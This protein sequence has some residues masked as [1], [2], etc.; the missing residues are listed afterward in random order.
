MIGSVKETQLLRSIQGIATRYITGG[1]KGTTFN[2]L[3]AH[4][5]LPPIDLAFRITQFCAASRISMLPPSHPLY[6]LACR[7]A[8][9]LIRSH[10]SPLHCLFFITGI[11]LQ[12]IEKILPVQC[13]PNYHPMMRSTIASNKKEALQSASI[14]HQFTHYKVYCDR[15]GFKGGIG[16]A[17]VLYKGR[18]PVKSL[19]YHLGPTNEHI[20]YEA[21]LMGMLL[22]FYLL[23]LLI[24]C[25]TP[26][27]I[28]GLDNQAAIC[29]LNNQKLKPA[30]YLLSQIHN[31]SEHLQLKQDHILHKGTFHQACWNNLQIQTK[32]RDVCDIHV[33]WVPGHS[34]FEPNNRVDKL[35]KKVAMGECSPRKDLLP[36]IHKPM[37]ISIS[38]I[39]QESMAKIHSIWQRC[40]KTSPQMHQIS[41]INS[42]MLSRKW[43]K[44]VNPLT[45]KQAVTLMQ[46]R[47]GHIAL[48]KH[49][50]CICHATSPLCPN[51]D[52][53]AKETVQHFLLTCTGY[54]QE[55]FLLHQKLRCCSLDILFLLSNSKAAILLLKYVSVTGRL[56][57]ATEVPPPAH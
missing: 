23:H 9:W 55:C 21:E 7:T 41:G 14:S 39:C 43:M 29:S 42:S 19:L 34:G 56:K 2:T 10:C 53:D 11:K 54:W 1:I 47:S 32:M 45:C 57:H 17:A 12:H 6:P 52:E 8:L 22:T 44:L 40:W 5:N 36:S 28:I 50:H 31:A 4:M 26:T 15:S 16:A 46:L 25:L 37:P 20:V 30:H 38:A 48:N 35:A 3:K 49:L 13:H 24:C 27:V 51:C 18:E 33:H